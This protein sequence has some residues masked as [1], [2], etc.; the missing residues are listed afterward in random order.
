MSA[1]KAKLAELCGTLDV[2]SRASDAPTADEIAYAESL[3]RLLEWGDD[4]ARSH[5]RS[6]A[7]SGRQEL[8]AKFSRFFISAVE[9]G[10]TGVVL[11]AT[12]N[13]KLMPERRHNT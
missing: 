8:R 1:M 3:L 5:V 9:N 11:R 12:A 4:A 13:L 10:P 7:A 6:K 2:T